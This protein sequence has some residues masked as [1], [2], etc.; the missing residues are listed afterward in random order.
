LGL[1]R[2]DEAFR[3]FQ[4]ALAAHPELRLSPDGQH[5]YA[6]AAVASGHLAEALVAYRRLAPMSG[7]LTATGATE[8]VYIEAAVLIMLIKP[9]QLQEAVAYLNEARRRNATPA[10]RSYVL[11]ALAFALHRQGRPEEARG[12]AHEVRGRV[13]LMLASVEA[14]TPANPSNS[15][16]PHLGRLELLPMIGML[17]AAENRS[18]ANVYFSQFVQEAPQ[19]HPWLSHVREKLA[20]KG[21]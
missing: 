2:A 12:V 13:G 17:A 18:L 10:L 8:C 4:A 11:A 14:E 21:Q 7:L 20:G 19:D 15:K 5:S 16:L 3:L 1:K 6:R 9:D